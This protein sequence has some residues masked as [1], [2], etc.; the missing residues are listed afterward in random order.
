[1]LAPNAAISPHRRDQEHAV[2]FVFERAL[3]E[4][5]IRIVVIDDRRFRAGSA[6][7]DMGCT[8]PSVRAERGAT[9]YHFPDAAAALVSP[10]EGFRFRL[11][12]ARVTTARGDPGESKRQIFPSDWPRRAPGPLPRQALGVPRSVGSNSPIPIEMVGMIA[13]RTRLRRASSN[14]ARS[15]DASS[16]RPRRRFRREIAN[17]SP[18]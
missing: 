13:S 11:P 14:A 3:G 18:P 9:G 6:T 1:M 17:S 15:R 12:P 10:A 2:S 16:R 5:T 4:K 8:R 7:L